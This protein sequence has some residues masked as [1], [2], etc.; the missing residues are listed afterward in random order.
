MTGSLALLPV[1]KI[2]LNVLTITLISSDETASEM[3]AAM[4]SMSDANIEYDGSNFN[5]SFADADGASV[6][7]TGEYDAGLD[8]VAYAWDYGTSTMLMQFVKYNSGYAGQYFIV[9]EDDST[10]TIKIIIDG[11]DI[12]FGLADNTSDPRV[13]LYGSAF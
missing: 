6:N 9:N 2:D 10:S 8:S 7:M 12:A 11:D 3:T 4:L 1:T 5:L 13:H